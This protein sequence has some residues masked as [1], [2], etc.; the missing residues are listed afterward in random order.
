MLL[1]SSQEY[2]NF[3]AWVPR[4]FLSVGVQQQQ[5]W[6]FYDWGPRSYPQPLVCLHALIGSAE[7]FFHQI[8]SLAPRGYRVISVHIPAY[9]NVADY[10]DAFHSFLDMLELSRIHIYGAGLGALLATQY[11]LRKPDRI[12]SIVMTHA[13]L[14]LPYPASVSSPSKTS[15]SSTTNSDISP[16]S[17][18]QLL[19]N[20]RS[21]M[22]PTPTFVTSVVP[23]SPGILRWLPPFFVRSAMRAL[24]PSGRT[25]SEQAYAAEFAISQT[26]SESRDVLAARLALVVTASRQSSSSASSQPN[27]SRRFLSTRDSSST[28]SVASVPD[29][30]VVTLIDTL[31][32]TSS[33]LAM[34]DYLAETLPGAR[35]AFLKTGGDFP[36]LSTPEDVNVLLIVHL[37]RHA[38]SPESPMPIPPP[39]KRRPLPTSPTVAPT[40]SP[41]SS[42]ESPDAT[43]KSSFMHDENID[44]ARPDNITNT[45]SASE[46]DPTNSNV[47][48]P[49]GKKI[50]NDL[51]REDDGIIENGN[52]HNDANG[53]H[54]DPLRGVAANSA[55]STTTNTVQSV[56]DDNV[57]N[58]QPNNVDEKQV[59]GFGDAV[60]IV[61]GEGYS[62]D[63]LTENEYVNSTTSTPTSA[64]L[65]LARQQ[66]TGAMPTPSTTSVMSPSHL[67]GR[68]PT[69]FSVANIDGDG[70]EIEDIDEI[71]VDPGLLEGIE[72][73][74][75]LA[76]SD[77]VAIADESEDKRETLISWKGVLPQ[78]DDDD[79][80]GVDIDDQPDIRD[81]WEQFRR[82]QIGTEEPED[83][84]N[85]ESEFDR[86]DSLHAES[87]IEA[88]QEDNIETEDQKRLRAW[89][90]SADTAASK[91]GNDT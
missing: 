23:Y 43:H 49:V 31:D 62:L 38:P 29:S 47:S 54:L 84:S 8:I 81:G 24:L 78:N 65:L 5:S 59:D 19:D 25:S 76:G 7:S 66:V 86:D 90:M 42:P 28:K 74:D 16:T 46:N 1:T 34:S 41:A 45:P 20:E 27:S 70:E 61:S 85:N 88:Q 60:D 48:T 72:P 40:F 91:S 12:V 33:A 32:R 82:R 50:S 58:N 2:A 4:N 21:S 36:Y 55:A 14:S 75:P 52:G 13:L 69:P 63:E 39:A 87:Q 71:V 22:P 9:W 37:R 44:D 26:M 17:A 30:R 57:I 68:G 56:D 18:S 10:C 6:L 35:R 11:A 73:S 79:D 15:S 77:A 80:Y 83:V 3:R 53:G 89:S 64:S 67:V 51:I